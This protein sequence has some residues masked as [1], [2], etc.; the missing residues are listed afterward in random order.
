MKDAQTAVGFGRRY[1][2][3]QANTQLQQYILK[4]LRAIKG[5][6]V[7]EDAFTATTPRGPVA[8]RNILAK[9]P[10][11]SGKGIAVSGHFDSKDM[12]GFVG[13][14][15]GAS[16]TGVLL[17]LARSLAGQARVDDV[18]IVFFDGEEAFGDWSDTDKLY[19][20]RHLA[21][22][23][24]NNGTAG[25]LKALINVD[26]IGDK[27]LN[28]LQDTSSNRQLRSLV[29][30]AAADLGYSRNF[31]NDAEQMDDDHMPFVQIGV[32]SL[33]LIDFDYPAWHTPAD[34]L[35]KLSPQSLRIVGEVVSESIRRLERP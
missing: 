10:G 17:E 11:T 18:W 8:M 35:D 12:P 25:K 20:S 6:Q 7:S 28:I 21:Q 15:D 14:N 31:T 9:F 5:A 26:M 24:K 19:G 34:T 30:K 1:S 4:E 27:D 33:D 3:S 22:V 32:P 29:W 23:W 13:A 2:G 16:S